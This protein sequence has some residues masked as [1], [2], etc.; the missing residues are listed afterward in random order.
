MRISGWAWNGRANV[1]TDFVSVSLRAVQRQ[2][3]VTFRGLPSP[4]GEVNVL[5]LLS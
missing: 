2:M 1:P 3:G 5:H 4:L